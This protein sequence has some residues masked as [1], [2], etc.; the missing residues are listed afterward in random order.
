VCREI[1]AELI[2]DAGDVVEGA[3]T[4]GIDRGMVPAE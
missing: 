2:G 4:L 1:G 3:D